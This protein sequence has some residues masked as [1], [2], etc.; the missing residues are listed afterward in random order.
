MPTL[1]NWTVAFDCLFGEIY[2]DE[3]HRF[4][5]GS[6]IRTSKIIEFDEENKV[7]K[8]EN[9]IYFLGKQKS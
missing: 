2:N 4:S 9:T 1:E 6:S 8:T 3:K 7:A 5:D